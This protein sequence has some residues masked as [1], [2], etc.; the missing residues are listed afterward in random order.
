MFVCFVLFCCVF[1]VSFVVF[2]VLAN[3][4]RLCN[5]SPKQQHMDNSRQQQQTKQKHMLGV[6]FWGRGVLMCSFLFVCCVLFVCM[7]C[8]VCCF[9]VC[10]SFFFVVFP[11]IANHL[12]LCYAKKNNNK[13]TNQTPT[14][15]PKNKQHIEVLFWGRDVLMWLFFGCVFLLFVFFVVLCS[16]F[17]VVCSYF[18]FYVFPVLANHLRLC[19]AQAA[20]TTHEQNQQQTKQTN[21]ILGCSFKGGCYFEGGTF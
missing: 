18:S 3:H 16:F 11:V 12:R 8:A 7:C 15:K 21:N 13:R 9:V 1:L 19:N 4:L 14:N 10:S 17:F 5:T 20:T 6:L 2:L